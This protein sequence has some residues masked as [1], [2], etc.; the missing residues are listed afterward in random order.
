MAEQQ[1]LVGLGMVLAVMLMGPIGRI[2]WK[3]S[4]LILLLHPSTCRLRGRLAMS[5]LA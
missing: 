1:F 5:P 2:F 3:E 4:F